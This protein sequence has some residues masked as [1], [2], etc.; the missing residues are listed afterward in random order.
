M[1]SVLVNIKV[2]PVIWQQVAWWNCW[3]KRPKKMTP[4]KN[5][6]IFKGSSSK[7]QISTGV[8]YYCSF[9]GSMSREGYHL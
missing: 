3:K 8:N 7:H 5:E 2:Y 6:R 9:R 4:P 1:A